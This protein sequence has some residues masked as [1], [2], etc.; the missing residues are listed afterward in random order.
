[1]R[2][3]SPTTPSTVDEPVHV[4][5]ARAPQRSRRVESAGIS[6]A[7]H[8]WG[9]EAAPP[10]LFAHGGFDFAR[11]LDVFAPL[12]ADAGWRV[13]CWD[14]RGHGDSEHASLYSWDADLRDMLA[15][16]DDTSHA[17][18]PVIG[19]SKGGGLAMNLV[20][21]LPERFTR[22][23]NLDGM[24]STRPQPDVAEHERVE[25][26]AGGAAAWLDHRRRTASAIRK[27]G[28]LDDLARRRGHMNPR[29]SQE[30]LRY[31][32]S[33]GARRDADGWRWKLD[34]TMRFGGFGP[35]RPQWGL[36][37]LPQL[38]V[39]LLGLVCTV[40]EPMAPFVDPAI[41][42]PHLPPE[43][44]LEALADTGH[45]VHIERPAQVAERVLAFLS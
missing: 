4:H 5:G 18:L 34:P 26:A 16:L 27:P 13:V 39:P 45:F 36:E 2:D 41:L 21:A 20:H 31:L 7:V 25:L 28:S 43:A 22:Y 19:H 37:R 32:A 38:R 42:R 3:A 10:L 24:P 30:W 9:D 1:V 29:L 40:E 6:L 35:W 12:L 11:T 15:V 14:Q 17:P 8:E 44:E 23:V 33:V